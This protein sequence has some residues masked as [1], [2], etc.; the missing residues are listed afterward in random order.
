MQSFFNNWF[1][2]VGI[3]R[4][5]EDFGLFLNEFANLIGIANGRIDAK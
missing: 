3:G 5:S 4:I 1:K 2:I